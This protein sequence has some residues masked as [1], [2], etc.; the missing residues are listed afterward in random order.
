MAKDWK[1]DLKEIISSQQN[2][3][4]KVID[5]RN[6]REAERLKKIKEI[7]NIIRPRFEYIKELI[8]SDKYLLSTFSG[9]SDQDTQ[10][11]QSAPIA[12][13]P[14][15]SQ[16]IGVSQGP[17]GLQGVRIPDEHERFI[18]TAKKGEMTLKPKINEGPAELVL[19]MPS[20]SDVNRLDLMYK[21]EFKDEKPV[22]HAFDL[23]SSGKM[24]NNGS[25]HDKFED[26]IQDT[27]K[28]FL[29]SWFTRKEGTELDKERKFTLVIDAHGLD[30]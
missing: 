18:E 28:R 19:I 26:F 11:E 20:L 23:V 1:S 22:L 30:R 16:Q 6:N 29:L 9:E 3:V 10:K 12:A 5:D 15:R 8:D 2:S 24:K 13:A 7:K 27:L 21:I 17:Q 14:V 4:K 25:A